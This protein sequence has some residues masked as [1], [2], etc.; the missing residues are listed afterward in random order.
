MFQMALRYTFFNIFILMLHIT[1]LINSDDHFSNSQF[2]LQNMDEHPYLN[3]TN[4]KYVDNDSYRQ[5]SCTTISHEDVKYNVLTKGYWCKRMVEKNVSCKNYVQQEKLI[6]VEI[7]CPIKVYDKIPNKKCFKPEKRIVNVVKY[8]RV[9]EK[10]VEK[11]CCPGFYNEI[12]NEKCITFESFNEMNERLSRLI[13]IMSELFY[14]IKT[15]SSND[16]LTQMGLWKTPFSK[17]FVGFPGAKGKK[18]DTGEP[19]DDG[20]NGDIGSNGYPG[21]AGEMGEKGE[22]GEQR[23]DDMKGYKGMKGLSIKGLPGNPGMLGDMGE[24]GKPGDI[25]KKGTKGSKG[26]PFN[27]Y[28]ITIKGNKGVKGIKGIKG[29]TGRAGLPGKP[30]DSID[31]LRKLIIETTSKLD[32]IEI[33]FDKMQDQVLNSNIGR[34][35]QTE[36]IT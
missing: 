29:D 28:P 25:G 11:Y 12:C 2:K 7:Q 18:G 1:L 22:K 23:Q 4:V 27:Y 6:Q 17:I 36:I 34:Q 33:L 10:T 31:K 35:N 13:K 5:L 14:L 32:E 8:D 3:G 16:R 24:K 30:A 20:D 9:L 15:D 21:D 26:Q 19:G